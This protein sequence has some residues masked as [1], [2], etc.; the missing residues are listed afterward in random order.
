VHQI[1]FTQAN[2]TMHELPV[3][4]LLPVLRIAI[5]CIFAVAISYKEDV[6]PVQVVFTVDVFN[7]F[8]LVIFIPTLSTTTLVAL[9]VV[10]LLQT[11]AELHEWNQ[12]TLR[13]VARLRSNR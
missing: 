11:A 4:L 5:K 13:L 2:H 9:M 1:L 6:V 8:Y 7:A 12:Q 3:P 10:D